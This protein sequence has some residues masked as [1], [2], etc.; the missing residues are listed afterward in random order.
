[1]P[2]ARELLRFLRKHGYEEKRQKGSHRIL[3]HPCPVH[4]QCADSFRATFRA[5]CSCVFSRTRVSQKKT[6][7]EARRKERRETRH[8][9]ARETV[10]M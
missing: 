5:D 2:T 6:F 1:M 4:A 8:Y 10:S 3:T 7:L 9:T